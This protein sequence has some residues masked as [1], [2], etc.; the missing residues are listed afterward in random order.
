MIPVEIPLL[1]NPLIQNTILLVVVIFLVRAL[2]LRSLQKSKFGT[3]EDRRR[4][5]VHVKNF[6]VAVLF[7]GLFLIWGTELRNFAL[8]MAAVAVAFAVASRELILCV[9]GGFYR[10]SSRPFEVGDRIAVADFRGDVVD[11]DFLN[12][13]LAEIGP[14]IHTHQFTG[15]VISIPNSYFLSHPVLNES[16]ERY[17]LHAFN[18]VT[19]VDKHWKVREKMLLEAAREESADYLQEAQ[20]FLDRLS[21]KEGFEAPNAEPRV[22]FHFDKKDEMTF[23]VRVPTPGLRKGR[24]EQAILH[25]YMERTAHL[26]ESS[27]QE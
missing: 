22:S 15:R 24:I 10:V 8:S 21:Q 26:L 16:R 1:K 6:F 20:R 7:I 9:L 2:V 19:P 11:H 17:Q 18:V 27:D 14:G 25:K 12:T 4:L 13:K 3:F 5:T 23:V